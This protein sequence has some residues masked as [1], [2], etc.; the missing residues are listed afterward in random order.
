MYGASILLKGIS[1]LQNFIKGR[2]STA[3]HMCF[4]NLLFREGINYG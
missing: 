4:L 1:A 3:N 2:E